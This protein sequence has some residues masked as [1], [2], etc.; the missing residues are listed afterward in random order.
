[1][2]CTFEEYQDLNIIR[3]YKRVMHEGLKNSF[4][5]LYPEEIQEA[6]DYSITNKLYNA[7]A[8][9]DNNYDKKRID[10]T[11]LDILRYIQ[12]LEPIKTSSGVLFKKHKKADN[13]LSR[14]VQ[15]FL[16]KR[17]VYKKEMFKDPKGSAEFEK[18]NLFQLLE[19]LN[20]CKSAVSG[21]SGDR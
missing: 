9:I 6:I 17:K 2:A 11:V 4:P 5:N 15:G 12:S 8:Y 20:A 13:P 7:P 3:H 21:L 1:M 18:Y 16:K 10:G 14:M 19:K